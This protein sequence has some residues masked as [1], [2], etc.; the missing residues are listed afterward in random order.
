LLPSEEWFVG[1]TFRLAPGSAAES[2]SRITELLKRRIATQ[3]LGEPNAGSVFRNP[4]GDYAGRLVEAAGLKGRRM[5]SARISELHANFIVAEP[6][7][8]ARDVYTLVRRV[9]NMVRERTGIELETEIKLIGDF[10]EEAHG[11]C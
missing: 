9:Q 6:G 11:Q 1:A 8:T 10:E 5:G 3:P 2:R 7:A 4:P